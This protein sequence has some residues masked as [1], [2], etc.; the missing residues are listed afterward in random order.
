MTLEQRIERLEEEVRHERSMRELQSE[1]MNVHD[2]LFHAIQA[3]HA[4][5]ARLLKETATQMQTGEAEMR[6]LR[7][8]VKELIQGLLRGRQNGK[9]G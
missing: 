4:E 6:E 1:R 7:A 9:E 5:T 3:H 2:R 8:L